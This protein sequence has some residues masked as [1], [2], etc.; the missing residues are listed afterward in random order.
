MEESQE[1][2]I[3]INNEQ[4]DST[5]DSQH[6]QLTKSFSERSPT[7]N[8][9]L[10]VELHIIRK[11]CEKVIE[12]QNNQEKMI[13]KLLKKL[14][15]SEQKENEKNERSIENEEI[16][17]KRKLVDH[18]HDYLPKRVETADIEPQ[19]VTSSPSKFVLRHVFKNVSKMK[20]SMN[21]FSDPEEYFGVPW[22]I[23]IV[24]G[25]SLAIDLQ[26]ARAD[27]S[28]KWS[29]HTA[30][31]IRVINP[32]G[33]VRTQKG[34]SHFHQCMSWGFPEFMK[35]DEMQK[36]YVVDD[37]LIVEVHVNIKQTVG[38]Y[39]D[40]LRNFDESTKE[41]SDIVL[42]VKDKKF[43]AAKLF[44][45]AHS[46]Y[47]KTMFLGRFEESKMTQITLNGVDPEDFQN[48]LEVLYGY[49]AIDEVTVEGIL[50]VGDMYDTKIVTE[51][52]EEFLAEK[53]KKALKKKLQLSVRYNLEKLKRKC[54]SEIKSIGG[55]RSAIPGD[56]CNL[57]PS[58]TTVLLEK[59]LSF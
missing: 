58:M 43:Y 36:D 39:K 3:P 56:L 54:L 38:I 8:L 31:E 30:Y 55:L 15:S 51:K 22:R 57:D 34:E 37:K 6:L 4:N 46:T 32:N 50:L 2:I 49:Y 19:S 17:R 13:D 29:I 42:N 12:K 41:F 40:N 25:E 16:N 21:Y 18:D 44:L 10:H 47:F 20:K 59:A 28:K 27:Y 5:A 45:A 48:Y 26:C 14:D 35:R 52:C 53:S 33:R 7:D 23:I 11:T 1:N 9:L 24:P